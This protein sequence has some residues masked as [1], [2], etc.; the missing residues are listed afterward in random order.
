MN[1]LL[2]EQHKC[3]VCGLN[4]SLLE[5]LG[6]FKCRE[7]QSLFIAIRP[8]GS[9]FW[10]CCGA[11]SAYRTPKEFYERTLTL[12]ALGCI[13]SDHKKQN[14]PYCLRPLVDHHT[15]ASRYDPEGSSVLIPNRLLDAKYIAPLPQAIGESIGTNTVVYMFDIQEFKLK[16]STK[17]FIFSYF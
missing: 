10:P 12:D 2:Q 15:Y 16:E 5:S 13:R 4:F 14:H 11:P 17:K 9:M 3:A 8:N 1:V 7:H 6:K